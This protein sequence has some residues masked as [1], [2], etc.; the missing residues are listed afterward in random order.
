MSLA[1]DS[2]QV[3]QCSQGTRSDAERSV[4]LP[5]QYLKSKLHLLPSNNGQNSAKMCWNTQD[6]EHQ[7]VWSCSNVI[8]EGLLHPSLHLI[9]NQLSI[10]LGNT[11]NT[12]FYQGW[13]PHIHVHISPIYFKIA[14]LSDANHSLALMLTSY[15]ISMKLSPAVLCQRPILINFGR[16]DFTPPC[17]NWTY[18]Q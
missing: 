12:C 15:H 13:P 3:V 6:P 16:Q 5:Y 4:S 14:C 8:N 1:L 10:W 11:P 17:T 9:W 2:Y 7:N 18:L